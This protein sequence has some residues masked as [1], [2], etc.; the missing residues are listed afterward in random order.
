MI[1]FFRNIRLDSISFWSGFIAATLL[2][3]LLW[4]THPAVRTLWKNIQ[5]GIEIVSQGLKTS[6]EQRH[7]LDTLKYVQK[8]HLAA[9]LFSLD[10]ILVMPRLMAP[11]PITDP[12]Q[13]P[14]YE[15]II[16]KIIPYAPDWPEMAA[17]YGTNTLDVFDTLRESGNLVIIGNAGTGKTTTLAFIAS[18]IARQ[19]FSAGP[20]QNFIPVFVHAANLALPVDDESYPLETIIDALEEQK[21]T[22]SPS[23]LSKLLKTAFSN[24]NVIL[25]VDGLDELHNK[26]INL[27]VN[28][29][30]TLLIQFPGIKV[31]TAASTNYIGN[32]PGIGFFPIPTAIWGQKNQ[33]NFIKKWGNL[34][35]EF[36]AHPAR[37]KG[38]VQIDPLLYNGWLINMDSGTTPFDFTL[39]VWSAYAGDSLGPSHGDGIEAYI[40]RIATSI[41]KARKTLE[42][43]AVKILMTQDSIFTESEARNWISGSSADTKPQY[44]SINYQHEDG[45]IKP[46]DTGI[47][48]AIPKLIECGLLIN[49][50]NNFIG[51]K[52]P[53]ISGYLA[54][55]SISIQEIG[56]IFSQQAWSLSRT[57]MEFMSF[58]PGLSDYIRE[59]LAESTDPLLTERLAI[60]RWF[61]NIQKNT[62]EHKAVLKQ[63]ASDLQNEIFPIDLRIRVLTALVTSGDPGVLAL[64]RHLMNSEKNEVRQ[65]AALGCGYLRD[66]QSI[67]DLAKLLGGPAE[68]GQAACLA[69]VNIGTK[70]ALEATASALLGG[71][72]QLARAAAEAFANHPI[73]GYPILKDGSSVDDILV[74]RA[75]IYGLR[76]VNEPWATEI[77]EE[78]QIED[79]Q[80]VIKDA[81]A[82][83]VEDINNPDPSI[84]KPQPPLMD[85]PWLIAFAGDRGLGISEE[86]P[87]RDMLLRVPTEGNED[88]VI[89]ALGQIRVRGETSIFPFAY[90]L[91][92]GEN[93][94]VKAAAF[95]TI[96]HISMMGIDIPPLDQVG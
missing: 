81:A 17:S 48:K 36:I 13:P 42:I 72:E 91:Y 4:M 90:T 27:V 74:R 51:F 50:Q 19:D 58:K 82:Q 25:L 65:L 57:T 86:K 73:E 12:D 30:E 55:S 41:P 28:Y 77:L 92:Y 16:G 76:K 1:Q 87:A 15:D 43:L 75:V 64:F 47:P 40:R 85:L 53:L 78:M 54:G 61:P 39:K 66:V 8:L 93:P 70:P 96:W 35:E 94:E 44:F 32:L 46:Q 34:W 9:P 60:G 18:E 62:P 63:L 67:G 84:P 6:N 14:P 52:H 11:P 23:R 26:R 3:W 31:V 89:A 5:K 29:L 7:R 10:E 69:L 88:E 38:D 56:D 68:V 20:F 49:S 80:W 37:R 83:A 71:D 21:S 95:N 59:T 24:K 33:V 2:W 79:A 45:E 22:L